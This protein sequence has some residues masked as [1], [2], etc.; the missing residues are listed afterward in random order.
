MFDSQSSVLNKMTFSRHNTNSQTVL[1]ISYSGE[2]KAITTLPCIC[3]VKV[4]KEAND[5]SR[6]IFNQI[7]LTDNYYSEHFQN[8]IL[9]NVHY[10]FHF[11]FVLPSSKNEMVIGDEQKLRSSNQSFSTSSHQQDYTIYWTPSIQQNP[12][13]RSLAGNWRTTAR[14]WSYTWINVLH[15][16]LRWGVGVNRSDI[17]LHASR[18]CLFSLHSGI[19]LRLWRLGHVF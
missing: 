6:F 8:F 4:E 13:W 1:L 10:Q 3:F 2:V 9:S 19:K 11:K 17:W 7:G 16:A 14:S 18:Q 12:V 5:L 15:T